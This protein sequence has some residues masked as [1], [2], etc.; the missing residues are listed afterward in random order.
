[1]RTTRFALFLLVILASIAAVRPTF[2]DDPSGITLVPIPP[3]N[4]APGQESVVLSAQLI[5]DGAP[6]AGVP[7]TFYVLTN[8]FG[9]RLMKVGDA[10]SDATGAASVLYRP[11]W[12]G[13][14]TVVAR[15]AG[16]GNYPA[17]QTSFSFTA[18]DVVSPWQPAEFGLDPVRRWLPLGVGVGILAVLATLGFTLVTTVIGIPAAAAH[19][20]AKQ[21]TYSWDA[22]GHRPAPL[23]RALVIMALLMI[24]AVFPAVWLIG[25]ARAPDDLTSS[26]GDIHST[27]A[28]GATAQPAA[29]PL[30]AILV[31]S[32]QTTTFD[33][34]GQPAPGSV[35]MP[36]DVAITAGRIRILDSNGGRIVTVTPEGTLAS[37]LN[38]GAYADISLKGAPAM[39][40]LGEKLYVV[41]Q[42]G[43]IVVVD[44]AGQ[45]ESV[46]TPVIPAGQAPFAPAGIALTESG[47]IWVSDSANHRVL[48]LNDRG[49][50]QQV[51]GE[52][53]PSAG[54]QGFNMP[55]GLALDEDGNLYV[56]DMMNKVVKKY[57]PLGILLQTIGDGRLDSP[58]AVAVD[59]EGTVFVADEAAHLVSAFSPDGAYLGSIGEG[60][61]EAPHSVKTDG[62]LLYVMDRLAGLFVF[63]PET[64]LAG[65]P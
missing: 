36:A 24:L 64:A 55:G 49:E 10:L 61:L 35:T 38:A 30:P 39:L 26:T 58:S 27:H 48:L 63:Q 8:V 19:T 17:T 40:A 47:E 21:P 41:T 65:G 3:P 57:S 59:E 50:F 9:E 29:E 6:V 33:Q 52:G 28:G 25:K 46:I 7:V 54:P 32:V 31:R 4:A 15:F 60:Q 20:P 51:I 14:H 13:D 62:G 11:T 56:A 1:M 34:G 43:P 2:A 42:D 37:I 22:G 16:N 5:S 53:I 12:D 23:G 45:I 44:S 18:Q